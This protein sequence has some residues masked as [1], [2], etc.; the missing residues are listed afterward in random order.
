MRE[1]EALAL[2]GRVALATPEEPHR[3]DPGLAGRLGLTPREAEILAHLTLG[4]TNRE[5]ARSLVISEKTTGIHVT[6]ILHKLGVQNRLEAA[7]IA[8]R[9]AHPSSR[10]IPPPAGP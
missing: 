8:H 1:L 4:Q 7:G 10:T 2:R 3:T 5:I 6:H 9:F